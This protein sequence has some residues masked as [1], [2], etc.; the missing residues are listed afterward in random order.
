LAGLKREQVAGVEVDLILNGANEVILLYSFF[1]LLLWIITCGMNQFKQ[2]IYK[3]FGLLNFDAASVGG[4][5]QQE[6][7][8]FIKILYLKAG[9]S[10]QI[11]FNRYDL[12]TDALFFITINQWYE[13]KKAG[14][15]SNGLIYYNRDFYCVEI[16]DKEVSCDGILYNNV[17]DIPVIFLSKENAPVMERVF[18]ELEIELQ[19]NDSAQE[20]ML[21]ILLKEIIIRSTRIWKESNKADD[22]TQEIE[23]LRQFSRLVELHFREYHSVSD[24]AAILNITPKALNKRIH[25]YGKLTP[26]EIIKNRIVLE[27]KRLLVHTEYSVKEI[28]YNLGYEDPAY[29]T[30]LFTKASEASPAEFKKNYYSASGKNV[31]HK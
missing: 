28:A 8:P 22:E 17:Y 26:N 7:N 2:F 6:F 13:V 18:N 16:H 1:F 4:V 11:D 9:S 23:F 21:R 24:Y 31:Q 25:K 19:N 20:E 3:K 14:K 27:A 30:R 5:N 10:I 15:G 12:K 29:F